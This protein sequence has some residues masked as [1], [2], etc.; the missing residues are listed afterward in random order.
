MSIGKISKVLLDQTILNKSCKVVE[1][2]LKMEISV[3][4]YQFSELFNFSNL[5]RVTLSYIERCFT[6]VVGSENFLNL[7][8]S[9][10]S[11]ILSSSQLHIT[12]ELK[13]FD[14]ADKWLSQNKKQCQK[15]AK[16]LL[17]KVRFHLLSEDCLKIVFE[18]SKSF[19]KSYEC[20][21]LINKVSQN[22]DEFF[23]KLNVHSTSRYCNQEL[24]RILICGGY[25]ER[26]K[27]TIKST[28]ELDVNDLSSVQECPSM[29]KERVNPKL[30]C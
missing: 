6:M 30:V 7:S 24:F 25:D 16:Q 13:I 21:E 3:A 10:L 22:K 18:N 26:L 5:N 2:K 14:A 17:L 8:F 9:S 19:S 1:E 12:S 20:R 15:F 4:V 11:K 23:K 28:K 27:T 29:I